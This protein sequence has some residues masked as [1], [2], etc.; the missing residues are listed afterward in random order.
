MPSTGKVSVEQYARQG[1][2]LE[3]AWCNRILCCEINCHPHEDTVRD[4]L[5]KNLEGIDKICDGH[6]IEWDGN[7]HVGRLTDEAQEYWDMLCNYFE[8]LPDYYVLAMMEDA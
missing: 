6:S 1:P 8:D 5:Q 4:F 3:E 7:N 2:L